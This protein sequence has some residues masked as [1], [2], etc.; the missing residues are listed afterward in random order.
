MNRPELEQLQSRISHLEFDGTPS[1]RR[2]IRSIAAEHFGNLLAFALDATKPQPKPKHTIADNYPAGGLSASEP[3]M[4]CENYEEL[5]AENARLREILGEIIEEH[6]CSC[7]DE[8]GT[9]LGN[10]PCPICAARAALAE[11]DQH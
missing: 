4:F 5:E 10:A 11:Q 8:Y 1:A 3:C 9:Q 7:V 2:E 6:F